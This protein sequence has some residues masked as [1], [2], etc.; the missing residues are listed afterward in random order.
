MDNG[1]AL[2][3]YV[4]YY[5]MG[6]PREEAALEDFFTNLFNWFLNFDRK[7]E[8]INKSIIIV[9]M[10]VWVGLSLGSRRLPNFLTIIK[11]RRPNKK[12]A[13]FHQSTP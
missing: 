2:K 11:H 1:R 4:A 7:K 3:L 9:C 10:Q 8:D 12:G 5:R 6:N 13:I